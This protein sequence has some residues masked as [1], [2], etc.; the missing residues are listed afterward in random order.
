MT[1]REDGRAVN[2]DNATEH[3]TVNDDW[4]EELEY[5]LNTQ[6]EK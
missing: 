6:H 3:D 4:E 1:N 2:I 5:I